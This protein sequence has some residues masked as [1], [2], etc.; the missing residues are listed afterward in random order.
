MYIGLGSSETS[1]K[2]KTEEHPGNHSSG[3]YVHVHTRN[4]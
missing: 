4:L 2:L 1:K 3:Q